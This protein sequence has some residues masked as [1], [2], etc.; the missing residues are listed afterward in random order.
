MQGRRAAAL[1]GRCATSQEAAPQPGTRQDAAA[2][3]PARG[4]DANPNGRGETLAA[5]AASGLGEVAAG[6]AAAS[7]RERGGRDLPIPQLGFP[8]RRPS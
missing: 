4:Q 5:C 6:S 3:P 8:S 2:T 1:P 7:W